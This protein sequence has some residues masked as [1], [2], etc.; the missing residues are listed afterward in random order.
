MCRAIKD[1]VAE[2][3]FNSRD[4]TFHDYVKDNTMIGCALVLDDDEEVTKVVE[5]GLLQEGF[6]VVCCHSVKQFERAF[7][8]RQFDLLFIDVTLPDGNGMDVARVIRSET[9]AGIIILT[10]RGDELDQVLGL[11]LGADDYITKPFRIR[12]LRAR[13]KAVHRRTSGAGERHAPNQ[14]TG[15]AKSQ[16]I[17]DLE[18]VRDARLVRGRDGQ[19]VDLTTLEFDVLSALAARPNQVLSRD[20][21]MDHVR[22]R[23]WS[24]Y[25]RTI[26]GLV[27]RLRKKLFPDG[28]GTRRIKTIRSIGYMMVKDI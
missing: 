10:G 12:E 19:P 4:V 9:A 2:W 17:Q 15:T 21:L 23:D 3:P 13:A 6:T 7:E 28:S 5:H 22:G 8:N 26:D 1:C 20:Q 14:N 18:I 25:D 24:A 16:T 11:E 27:S